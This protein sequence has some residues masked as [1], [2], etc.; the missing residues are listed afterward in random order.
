MRFDAQA[1]DKVF[2]RPVASKP[3]DSSIPY[4]DN[5]AD[6]EGDSNVIATEDLTNANGEE[7]AD[8]GNAGDCIGNSEQ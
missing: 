8:N 5:T 4:V 3:V 2:P 6:N 7:V 1:Y